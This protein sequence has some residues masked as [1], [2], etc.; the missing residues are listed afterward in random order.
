MFKSV[1]E[2]FQLNKEKLESL[3]DV[4]AFEKVRGSRIKQKDYLGK[5]KLIDNIVNSIQ[6]AKERGESALE[7]EITK[8]IPNIVKAYK[9]VGIDVKPSEI[10]KYLEGSPSKKASIKAVLFL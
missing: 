6:A 3:M 5:G 2:G 9:E 8:S 7:K 1:K 10:S 4:S